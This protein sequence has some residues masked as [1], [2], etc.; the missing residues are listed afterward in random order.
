LLPD[1]DSVAFIQNAYI[2]ALCCEIEIEIPTPPLL[3]R[4]PHI[5]LVDSELTKDEINE[6][7]T[8]LA[9]H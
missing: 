5:L 7:D 1:I 6:W 8:T 2:T 4:G 3:H 9:Y